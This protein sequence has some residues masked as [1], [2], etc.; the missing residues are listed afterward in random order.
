MRTAVLSLLLVATCAS[1]RVDALDFYAGAT[2]GQEFDGRFDDAPGDVDADSAWKAF[3]GVVL[4]GPWRIELAY[5]DFGD[6][7]CCDPSVVNFAFDTETDG[8]SAGVV[9]RAD[10]ERWHPF[11]KVGYA[12]IDTEGEAS[13]FVR[14]TEID[15]T[16]GGALAEVGVAFDV[17]PR[18]ALRAGFEWFDFDGGSDAVFNAGAEFTFRESAVG[19]A[20]AATA[21]P[22]CRSACRG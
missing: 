2:F 13:L 11:A 10:L 16:D 22:P 7:T 20:S 9:Y 6:A 12:R 19:A 18:F 3:G 8:F 14:G 5:H 15:D 17:A 4:Q 21:V 1:P